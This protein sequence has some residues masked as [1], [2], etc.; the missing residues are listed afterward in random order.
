MKQ[1]GIK[2]N[3]YDIIVFFLFLIVIFITKFNTLNTPY[4]WDEMGWVR[5]THWLSGVNLLRSIPGFHPPTTFWGHP[6]ALHVSLAS[7]YKLFGESIW[8]SHLLILWFS[9]LGAYFTYL[10][11]NCLYGR[12]VGIFSA[13]FLYFSAIY[14]AQSGMFLGDIPVTALGVMSIYFTLRKKYIPYLVCAVYMVMIKET[15]IAIVFSL[16]I[17]LFLTEGYRSKYTFKEISKYGVPLLVI[18]AFSILQKVTTGKFCCIYSFKFQLFELQ[19]SLVVHQAFLITK[20]LFFY[21]YRYIFTFLIVLN[22][23]INKASRSQKELLLFLPIFILSGYS[24]SFLYFLPRYLLPAL[25]YFYVLGAWSLIELIKSKRLQTVTGTAITAVLIYSLSGSGTVLYG[26]YEWDMKYL[27]VVKIHKIMC[28]YIEEKFPNARVLTTFPHTQQLRY[29]YLGYVNKPLKVVP[30]KEEIDLGD[31]DL[32]LFSV[33]SDYNRD[34]FR[35]YAVSNNLNLIKRL[36]K[37]KII[38]ELYAKRQKKY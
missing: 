1:P 12:K 35:D 29:P 36:E 37:D 5:A 14:F 28:E 26:N 7:L 9:F 2:C 33:P 3:K 18:A 21:Q 8:L 16:L 32:I 17:Y 20:W 19:P 11:G 23:I 24:F 13:L 38:S 15:A 4:Y 10:L 34:M 30:F 31:F 6:P 22:L 25:P 27:E